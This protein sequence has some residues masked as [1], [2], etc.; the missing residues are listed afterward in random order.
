MTPRRKHG[1][2]FTN[3]VK[4]L[5]YAHGDSSL[6]N[7][8][9]VH[10]LEDVLMMYIGDVCQEAN[11]FSKSTGKSKLGVDD[12]KFVLRNDPEKLGRVEELG[13]MEKVIANAKRT[14][15]IKSYGDDKRKRREN[16]RQKLERV[17]SSDEEP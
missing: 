15:D 11:Y 2:I 1:H 8:E 4:S 10:T 12:F 13:R 14:T 6:P 16:K 3:D 17:N 9:T 7:L 5:L